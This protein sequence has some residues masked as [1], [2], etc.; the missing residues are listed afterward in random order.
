M[1]THQPRKR[2]SPAPRSAVLERMNT[3]VAGIDCGATHRYVAVVA[4]S[5]GLGPS[6]AGREI[7]TGSDR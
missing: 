3:N 5:A 1:K 2:K 7:A 4:G 6:G